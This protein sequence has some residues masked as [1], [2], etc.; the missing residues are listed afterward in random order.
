MVESALVCAVVLVGSLVNR[1]AWVLP[2]PAPGSAGSALRLAAAPRE[3][4]VWV[5]SIQW[6]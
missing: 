6:R 4:R 3:A 1:R 5:M 2:A